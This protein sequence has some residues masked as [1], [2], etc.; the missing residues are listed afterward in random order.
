MCTSISETRP[1]S[2]AGKGP[3]GWFPVTQSTV[4]FDHATHSPA[5]H[6]LLLDFSNYDLGT[7]ARVG[8]ELDIASGRALVEQLQRAIEAATATGLRD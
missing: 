6:A 2:G 7:H 1:I 5:E 3:S 8:I 4:G